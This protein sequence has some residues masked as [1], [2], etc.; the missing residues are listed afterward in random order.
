ML[1]EFLYENANKERLLEDYKKH[2]SLIVAYDFDN[3]V[4]DYHKKGYTYNNVISLLR[5]CHKLGF[6]LIV[7]TC[8]DSSKHDFLINYLKDNS[9][10]YDSINKNH[11]STDFGGDGKLYYNILLDDRAGLISAYHDLKYVI[12]KV[13]V[14]KND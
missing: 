14:E 3:T 13:K 8:K 10:P 4:Y 12:E 1:D 2:K 7:Y 9:I 5:E 11:P 6:Y